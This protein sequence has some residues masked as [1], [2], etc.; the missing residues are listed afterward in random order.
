MRGPEGGGVGGSGLSAASPFPTR[1]PR[2]L[3]SVC[4]RRGEHRRG[5]CWGFLQEAGAARWPRRM[6]GEHVAPLCVRR[7]LRP[8]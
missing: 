4:G 6:R 1:R 8:G 7:A 2:A 3:S 5:L